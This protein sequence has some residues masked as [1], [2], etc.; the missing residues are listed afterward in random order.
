MKTIVQQK[1]AQAVE[2]LRE[3]NIDAW[4]TFVRE[5]SQTHDPVLDVLLGFGL[6]W[7]QRADHHAARRK[8]RH[9]WPLR[10]GQRYQT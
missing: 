7:D 1:L 6:T 5:T 2:L 8:D 10:R 4:I 9:R 3:Q